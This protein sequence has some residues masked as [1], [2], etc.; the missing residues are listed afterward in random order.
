MIVDLTNREVQFISNV[1]IERSQEFFR[2]DS[3]LELVRRLLLKAIFN[4]ADY[5]A[6]EI[7]Y[8]Q[9]AFQELHEIYGSRH[10][11]ANEKLPPSSLSFVPQATLILVKNISDKF[12]ARMKINVEETGYVGSP[13]KEGSINIMKDPL[14]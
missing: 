14:L 1:L 6:V 10:S 4:S 12:G 2:P 13:R 8:L 11:T 7:G 3:E 5:T 9:F